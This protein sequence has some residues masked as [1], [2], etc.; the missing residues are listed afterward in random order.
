MRRS[1]VI[2][3][4]DF[5]LPPRQRLND[6]VGLEGKRNLK[7]QEEV[8]ETKHQRISAIVSPDFLDVKISISDARVSAVTMPKTQLEVPVP[9]NEDE[10][11]LLLL[12]T[13]QN[14]QLWYETA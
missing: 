2:G 7:E 14:P 3:R 13:F 5:P 4:D 12:K 9:V 8:T 1:L 11:E 10:N 6:A